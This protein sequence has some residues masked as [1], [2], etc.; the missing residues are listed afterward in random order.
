VAEFCRQE[1]VRVLDL[2]PVF[3]Q[4]ATAGEQ[5]YFRFDRHWN[6]RGNQLVAETILTYL[7]MEGLIP[8][9]VVAGN[10]SVGRER[11]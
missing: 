8:S 9:R 2:T 6:V 3:R 5:L 11:N 1:G 7:R 10:Q 4:R